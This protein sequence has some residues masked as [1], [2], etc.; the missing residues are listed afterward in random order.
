MG[1]P[2]ATDYLITEGVTFANLR[3]ALA[4]VY[5]GYVDMTD[6]YWSDALR[7]VVPMQHNI[8]NPIS[9]TKIDGTLVARDTFIEFWIDDDDRLTQDS[10][11][12]TRVK[13]L[14]DVSIPYQTSE[15]LKVARITVRFVGAKGEAWAKLFHHVVKR[16]EVASVF[17]EYCN[18][19]ALDYIG[20]IRPIN[21]DY[22][23]AQNTTVAYDITMMLQYTEVIK[24]P[25]ERLGLVSLADGIVSI[26]G[27]I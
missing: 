14:E 4:M 17:Y 13:I 24:L 11:W 6:Q 1:E 26:E 19:I 3:A 12:Q 9:L 5:F 2:N 22:F 25:G 16:P 7:H 20:S 8:E 10:K 15:V 23:G 18:A 27:G 21:V